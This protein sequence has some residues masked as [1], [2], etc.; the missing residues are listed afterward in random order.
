MRGTLIT[1]ESKNQRSLVIDAVGSF[2]MAGLR[3]RKKHAT[4][5]AIHEAGLRL[6]AQQG[7]AATT[8][9]QIAEAADVS[10]ATVFTYYAAKEDV[11]FGDA[12][13][14]I[15]ALADE[16]RG[17]SATI[18]A[19]REWLRPLTGWIDPGLLLQRRL[20]QEVPA[21]G[22]R[23]AQ[24]YRV[25]EPPRWRRALEAELGSRPPAQRASGRRRADRGA[26]GRRGRGGGADGARGPRARTGR[27]RR[28]PRFR[29]RLRRGRHGG[30]ARR[31]GGLGLGPGPGGGASSSPGG[32]WTA[33]MLSGRRKLLY[34][35]MRSGSPRRPGWRGAPRAPRTASTRRAP[36]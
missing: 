12:P 20:A 13:L 1:T 21:I 6:F 7:F 25:V 4:R 28:D 33:P 22:A 8:M 23:R 32:A 34:S 36:T 9:D 30:A 5:K 3:E 24:H 11:V 27:G 17:V 19:V 15:A 10:R 35:M 31:L 18:P 2:R 29:G 14:A 16:L 26:R